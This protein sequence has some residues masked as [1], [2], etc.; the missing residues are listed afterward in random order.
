M[1][2]QA[3]LKA[4]AN[5][6]GGVEYCE[7]IRKDAFNDLKRDILIDY[8]AM[9]QRE[10]TSD[11]EAI[12]A[13][14]A[15]LEHEEDQYMQE[16]HG[17]DPDA[18][19]GSGRWKKRRFMSRARGKQVWGVP[20]NYFNA[21]S[22]IINALKFGHDPDEMEKKSK[23]E[24]TSFNTEKRAEKAGF[25]PEKEMDKLRHNLAKLAAQRDAIVDSGF[26]TESTLNALITTT[27]GL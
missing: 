16:H 21:K 20:P 2:I 24:L 17:A 19:T 1:N 13:V 4:F 23:A 18:K 12:A 6:E 14:E 7:G 26:V 27:L 3:T 8:A 11:E 5:A 25:S 22:V 9:M 15:A 10:G